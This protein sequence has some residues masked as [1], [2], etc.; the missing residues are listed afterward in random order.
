[1]LD[2]VRR[3]IK[4]I[5]DLSDEKKILC[6]RQFRYVICSVR[7]RLFSDRISL[8]FTTIKFERKQLR[9][10]NSPVKEVTHSENSDKKE[11]VFFK[12]I[13]K[14]SEENL[15]VFM[16]KRKSIIPKS[17]KDLSK[18]AKGNLIG[19]LSEI[20]GVGCGDTLYLRPYK[21]DE[22]LIEEI[23][24]ATGEKKSAVA[25][26]LLHLALHAS[27]D[28]REQESRQL[29]LLDWLII[30]EKH[31]AAQ[32][33]VAE[34]RL[35]RLEEHAE[36][37][38]LLQTAAENSR[39]TRIIVSEIYCMVS[40]CMSYANQIFTK[41]VEYFSPHEVER[42]NSTDFAN[43]NILGLVEHSLL[44]L[45]KIAEHYGLD[46]EETEPELLYLFTKIEKIKERL[47]Q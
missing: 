7:K 12:F 24:E 15:Q 14:N 43:R 46:L 20:S 45:E 34:A 35:E 40:V 5:F 44:E 3:K 26:K 25:Q 13:Q 39:F 31:K 2:S 22:Q 8:A 11:T 1:M 4:F 33:D 47:V 10:V 16:S 42:K 36:L 17:K 32:S 29:E 41:L 21:G 27:L 6:F 38:R 37:E 9:Q 28:E 23:S 18:K 19:R 30:N